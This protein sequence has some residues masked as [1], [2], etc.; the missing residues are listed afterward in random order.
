MIDTT[1]EA[2]AFFREQ[3]PRDAGVAHKLAQAEAWAK[4]KGLRFEWSDDDLMIDHVAEFDGYDEQPE[5]CEQCWVTDPETGATLASL[6]CVDDA[7]DDY[8]RVVEAELAYEAMPAW[9]Q[10]PLPF[11]VQAS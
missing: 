8:R 11:E 5:T 1:P 9:F 6:G 7:T 4:S 2:E 3:V 10:P